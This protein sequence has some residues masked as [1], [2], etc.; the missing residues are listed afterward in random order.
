M[1]WGEK[2]STGEL[3]PWVMGLRAV[4]ELRGMEGF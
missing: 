2:S 4:G 3:L 1:V